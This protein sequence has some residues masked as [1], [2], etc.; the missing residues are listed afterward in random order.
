R[1]KEMVRL[2]ENENA[3]DTPTLQAEAIDRTIA[4]LKSFAAVYKDLPNLT[5]KAVATAATRKASNQKKFLKRVKNDV[6]L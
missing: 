3:T 4:A 6:G 1:L 5:I 2:S